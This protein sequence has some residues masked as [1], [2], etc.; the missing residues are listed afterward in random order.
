[1]S[2]Q[3]SLSDRSKIIVNQTEW[4][5][6]Q[7]GGGGGGNSKQFYNP[8]PRQKVLGHLR[9]LG[10]KTHFAQLYSNS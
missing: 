2:F 8:G 4:K 5:F 10:T 7:G 1:M 9:K 3:I 6:T